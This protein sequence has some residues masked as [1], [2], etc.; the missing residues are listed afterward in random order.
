MKDK[1][2]QPSGEGI[3]RLGKVDNRALVDRDIGGED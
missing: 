3:G 1:P 2:P